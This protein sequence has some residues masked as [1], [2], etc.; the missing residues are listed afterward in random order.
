MVNSGNLLSGEQRH[1][2][3]DVSCDGSTKVAK[4]MQKTFRARW[5]K[6]RYPGA[7]GCSKLC[8]NRTSCSSA[9]LSPT[10]RSS[11][12]SGWPWSLQSRQ[13]ARCHRPETSRRARPGPN[14]TTLSRSGWPAWPDIPVRFDCRSPGL[15]CRANFNFPANA[16]SFDRNR[17]IRIQRLPVTVCSKCLRN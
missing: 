15:P 16:V 5:G 13:S 12:G 17:S 6:C 7:P 4:G 14:R 3:G 10:D 2:Q 11:L 1:A 9:A 8:R